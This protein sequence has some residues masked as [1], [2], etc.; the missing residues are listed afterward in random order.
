MTDKPHN[1]FFITVFS[2]KENMID[3]ITQFLPEVAETI[4]INSLALDNNSYVNKE[5]KELYA[6]IVYTCK[7]KDGRPLKV[8]LLLEHK[9]YTVSYP[10]FQLLD[11]MVSIF[12][13]QVKNKEPLSLVIPIVFY[14]GK[15]NWKYKTLTSYYGNL[16]DHLKSYIPDFKYHIIDLNAYSDET[17]SS[18]KV[19][20]LINAL[21]AFKHKS[22]S[23]YFKQSLRKVYQHIEIYP[24]TDRTQTFFHSLTVYI[25]KSTNITGQEMGELI[26]TL[27]V[28]GQEKLKTTYDNIF[29]LGVEEGIEKGIERGIEKGIKE[30]L[31]KGI[32][33]GLSKAAF[34]RIAAIENA[35]KIG[36]NADTIS[37][38]FGVSKNLVSVLKGFIKEQESPLSLKIAL[39]SVMITD[40]THLTAQ[41]IATFC[42][43]PIEEVIVLKDKIIEN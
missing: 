12:R 31:E 16:A 19:G 17:I 9:S 33:K 35:I 18:L 21:L 37:T 36:L 2:D 20:F 10:R 25:I 27:P 1:N 41:D 24:K 42:Q 5:L 34:E 43:L 26:E 4:E 13:N 38:I 11:Y 29:D 8:T 28:E 39:A 14:Q 22:N 3:L 15:T 30:G 40:F 6:D 23:E 32:I 7:G